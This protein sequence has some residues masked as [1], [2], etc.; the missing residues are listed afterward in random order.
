MSPPTSSRKRTWVTEITATMN[1][2]WAETPAAAMSTEGVNI[3]VKPTIM[4]VEAA[5]ASGTPRAWSRG[6]KGTPSHWK[7]GV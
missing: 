5:A 4:V 1:R 6:R 7:M 2:V 3:S